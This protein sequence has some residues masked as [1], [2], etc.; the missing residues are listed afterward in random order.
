[1]RVIIAGSREATIDQVN[2]ALKVCP[3]TKRITS[4][5][6]GTARGADQAGELWAG[7]NKITLTRF[8]ADWKTHGKRAGFMRNTLMA[9]N[10]DG[11][12]AVWD[13]ESCGTQHMIYEARYKGLR[14]FVHRTDNG[15]TLSID[16]YGAAAIRWENND[17][18]SE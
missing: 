10:A 11:L 3:W 9:E 2:T 5:L 7:K 13:G 1:M 18:R 12:I 17:W 15:T 6:S 8:P 4:V 16:E 14:V